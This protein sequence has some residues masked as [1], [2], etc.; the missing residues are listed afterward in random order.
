MEIEETSQ[1][2]GRFTANSERVTRALLGT[3]LR[4]LPQVQEITVGSKARLICDR[5]HEFERSVASIL[6]WKSGMCP[7][8][9]SAETEVRNLAKKLP[10]P[11]RLGWIPAD[12]VLGRGTKP[13]DLRGMVFGQLRVE[14]VVGKHRSGSLLWDCVCTCGN[15]VTKKSSTLTVGKST[16]CGCVRRSVKSYATVAPNKGKTYTIK[17]DDEHFGSRKAWANA[18]KKKKGDRCEVCGW[19]YSSCDVHHIVERNQ[20]GKNTIENALVLCPNHHRTAHSQ[21]V[22]VLVKIKTARES[23]LSKQDGDSKS[24]RTILAYCEYTLLLLDYENDNLLFRSL[25]ISIIKALEVVG[26][27]LLATVGMHNDLVERVKQI[28]SWSQMLNESFEFPYSENDEELSFEETAGA[29]SKDLL[30]MVLIGDGE[31]ADCRDYLHD[32]I[33]AYRAGL[34]I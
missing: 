7:L 13:R 33:R 4:L 12:I 18:V 1:R 3:K 9:R 24:S 22:E 10:D 34:G 28:A 25:W 26:N 14:R 8:C 29:I 6:K 27:R 11:N 2:I 19:S 30:R 16:S 17:A 5:S 21:G 32:S 23:Y 15:R 20:G 31:A